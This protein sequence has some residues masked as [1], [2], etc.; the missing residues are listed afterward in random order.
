M[1]VE[2]LSFEHPIRIGD[3]A[4]T[5]SVRL[6]IEYAVSGNTV[7]RCTGDYAVAAY[8]EDRLYIQIFWK[9][10]EP[11][12]IGKVNRRIDDFVASRGLTYPR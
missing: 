5:L 9:E 6:A 7:T 12:I 1:P 4:T 10:L 2:K 3:R 8:P 11:I